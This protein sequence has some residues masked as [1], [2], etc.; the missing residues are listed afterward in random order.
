[1]NWF[2]SSAVTL[3]LE[4]LW[5]GIDQGNDNNNGFVGTFTPVGGPSQLVF[6]PQTNNNDNE[7]FVAR[8]KLNFKF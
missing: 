4:G 6:A 8:A 7:F 2:G 1:M 5:V 3:G